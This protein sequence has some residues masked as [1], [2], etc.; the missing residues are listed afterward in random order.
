V[1][2]GKS[3]GSRIGCHLALEEPAAAIVCLGYPL[4][5]QRGQL[6]DE[7]LLALRTPVLFVQGSRDPLGPLE[8]LEAVRRRMRAPSALHVVEGGGHGLEVNARALR[9]RGET[10]EEVEA[11][12]LG[13]IAAFLDEHVAGRPLALG[14]TQPRRRSRRA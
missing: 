5:G 1:L 12:A 3:M 7:V 14:V 9:D 8:V 6:R 2:A 11:R 4:R 10:Q 13:A